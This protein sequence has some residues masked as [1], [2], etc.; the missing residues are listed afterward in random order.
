MICFNHGRPKE[1]GTYIDQLKWGMIGVIVHEVGHNFFPM[2]INSDERQTTWMDEGL[3]TFVQ[4]LTQTIYYPDMPA[5]RGPAAMIVPYMKSDPTFQR[6][7]MV[8]S[9]T[10][11]AF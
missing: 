7:L 2:I 9:E 8:N 11:G 5:R 10:S 1:D 6:P 4:F 3:N